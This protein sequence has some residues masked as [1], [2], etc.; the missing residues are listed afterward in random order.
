MY[1]FID[2]CCCKKISIF[3]VGLI[4]VNTQLPEVHCASV[5]KTAGFTSLLS[6][7][8]L[9][10][11]SI[12]FLS[13]FAVYEFQRYINISIFLLTSQISS[14]LSKMCMTSSSPQ[15]VQQLRGSDEEPAEDRSYF[16]SR[17]PSGAFITQQRQRHGLQRQQDPSQ[18]GV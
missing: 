14:L 17:V 13:R 16:L 7:I 1:G 10:T 6:F 3:S 2:L 8:I 15:S 18:P 5:V 4:K 9:E 12:T 11:D